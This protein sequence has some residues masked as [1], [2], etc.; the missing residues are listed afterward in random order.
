MNDKCVVN[1]VGPIYNKSLQDF[2]DRFKPKPQ[3][4]K[5][6]ARTRGNG[7]KNRRPKRK[8]DSASLTMRELLQRQD[9]RLRRSL[10][11]DVIRC[12]RHSL[13]LALPV[14]ALSPHRDRFG[15]IVEP[16]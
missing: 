14:V 3:K 5:Q 13:R 6:K 12:V 10:G 8:M 2:H 11:D 15:P 9:L 7:S 4:S 1:E 16:G